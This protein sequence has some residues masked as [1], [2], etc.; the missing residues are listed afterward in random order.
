MHVT[1]GFRAPVFTKT[2]KAFYKGLRK[3]KERLEPF[4]S[5]MTD[6]VIAV[7]QHFQELGVDYM[8]IR[9][10]GSGTDFLYPRMWKTLIK[11]NLE[12]VFSALKS[13]K[14]NRIYGSTD[15]IIE[16]MNDCGADAVSVDQKNSVAGSRAKPGPD[17]M[18]LANF[19][20]YGT[21][22]QMEADEVAEVVKKCVD[23]GVEAVWPGCDIWPDVKNMEAHIQ[24]VRDYGK[25]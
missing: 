12:R 22:V 6:L 5:K 8:N 23:D 11:P 10:M 2:P 9:E 25:K 7:A 21:L 16:M 4:L 3:D 20:P 15:L 18:I 24:A 1:R 14:I 19:D 13:P 17:V